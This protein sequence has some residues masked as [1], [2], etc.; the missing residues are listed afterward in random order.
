M[1]ECDKRKSHISR[2]LR[3]KQQTSPLLYTA[4]FIPQSLHL[5]MQ[6]TL[7]SLD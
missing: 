5:L 7:T 3:L 4:G 1:K 6:V 2:K